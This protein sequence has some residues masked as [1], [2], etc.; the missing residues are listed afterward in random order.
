MEGVEASAK[1]GPQHNNLYNIDV[2][3]N[4]LELLETIELKYELKIV[5][6]R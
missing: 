1:N 5:K 3:L 6:Y 4:N 2:E